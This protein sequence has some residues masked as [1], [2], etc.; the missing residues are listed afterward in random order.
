MYLS[1]QRALSESWVE[2]QINIENGDEWNDYEWAFIEKSH[3]CQLI[4]IVYN[5]SVTANSNYIWD[6]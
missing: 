1:C 5:F 6:Y 3:H 2:Y 4:L